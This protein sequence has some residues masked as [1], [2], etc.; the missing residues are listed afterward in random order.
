MRLRKNDFAQMKKDRDDLRKLGYIQE[1]N[2]SMGVFSNFAASFAIISI[3]TGLNSLYGYGLEHGGLACIWMV[4]CVGLCQL[5]VAGALSEI[6]SLYPVAGG[7]YK[8]TTLYSNKTF[9]W[10]CGWISLIGWIACVAGADYGFA[11]FIA[12]FFNIPLDNKI[13][14]LD[15][16]RFYYF[17]PHHNESLWD[18]IG[19]IL[20][21]FQRGSAFGR[22]CA[23]YC[24]FIHIWKSK[25]DG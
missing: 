2:R 16:D 13:T 3:L 17:D 8:W 22:C 12:A 7:V 15:A 23:H 21:R 11:Q 24:A 20:L 6:A 10:F 9:G 19:E 25:Y 14:M 1:L 5:A 4:P 18:Q